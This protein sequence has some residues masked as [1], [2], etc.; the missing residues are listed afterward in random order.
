VFASL[1]VLNLKSNGAL[2]AG[3]NESLYLLRTKLYRPR[4]IGGLVRRP[5][6]RDK[7]ERSIDCPL[8]LV[9][10]PAGYGKTTLLGDWLAHSGHPNAWLTLD[11]DD[12]DPA[13][14]LTYFVAAI[15]T[16]VPEACAETSTLLH[17]PQ[18]PPLT[19][20]ASALHNDLD[21]LHNDPA[22]AGG[23]HFVLV[24]DD[25]HLVH[26]PAVHELLNGLLQRPPRTMHLI[27]STRQ[28]PPLN[29]NALRAHG[30]MEEIRLHDLRFTDEEAATFMQQALGS[31]LDERILVILQERTEGWAAGLRLA[32]L[33][34]DISTDIDSHVRQLP[35]D[36]RYIT[37]Y[38]IDEV[39]SHIPT[40]SQDFLLKTSILELLS[41]PLCDA[42]T[43]M[44]GPVWDGRA[45]LEWLSHQGLFTISL[46]AQGQWYRYHL[47]FRALLRTR[48][49]QR[50][51]SEEIVR[52]H[53]EASTW[54]A[55]HGLVD[56]A[57]R[58]ALAGGDVTATVHL[59]ETHRHEAMNQE[60]WRQLERWL[61]L[62]AGRVI[63][64][65]LEL[66]LLEAWT[67]ENR[68]RLA[69]TA[70]CLEGVEALMGKALLPEG[71]AERLQA[72]IDALRA[73]LS[74]WAADAERCEAFARRALRTAPVEHSGVRGHAWVFLAAAMQMRGDL[75]GALDLVYQGLAEDRSPGSAFAT[76]LLLVLS[77][78]YWISTDLSNMME[79]ANHLLSLA[80]EGDLPE[81][82]TRGQYY[83]GMAHYQRN[84]LAAAESAF[85]AVLERRYVAYPLVFAQSAFG[86]ASVYQA[87]GFADR[88]NAT[89]E[90]VRAY[91]LEMNNPPMLADAQAFGAHLALLQ[92]RN[93]EALYWAAQ[94]DRRIRRAP[95]PSFF[96]PSFALVEILLAKDTPA[97]LEEASQLLGQLRDLVESTHNTRFAI[98][99][100]ALQALLHDRLHDQTAAL[101]ALKQALVLAEPG[102]LIRVFVDLGP[103]MA[104]LLHQLAAPGVAPEYL[105]KLLA[106]FHEVVTPSQGAGQPGLIEPLSARELEVLAL[107][108]ERLSNKEIAREMGISPMTVKRHTVNIYQKLLVQGRREAAARAVELG[109]LS[110]PSPAEPRVHG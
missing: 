33:T 88:A 40:A 49:E 3:K 11:E 100:L 75:R 82:V 43:G 68:F 58:H 13:V 106:A 4:V 37:D 65:H 57:I 8:T 81:S 108:G 89:A 39:L 76:R 36:N 84:N 62:F 91:A 1:I 2:V 78:I 9:C 48:L 55:S 32:A 42:V 70:A 34:L 23:E 59:V 102:G 77:N 86:L 10:A 73:Q 31:P 96:V 85:A 46:D 12:S 16:I 94:C 90:S 20:L 29:L 99:A 44:V 61:G 22:L 95:M 24:L 41:G 7:L 6:V 38:L 25:Y 74:Y 72:E 45:Y 52:L 56:E 93:A 97:D 15:R 19:G 110:S 28:D 18:L 60:R 87:Q 83:L 27:L 103:P 69:D 54:Y 26:N 98:E 53:A 63:D 80:R 92:G 107:L 105:N 5:R 47:L 67:L 17:S 21:R 71:I 30:E 35:A 50:F 66:L 101:A 14:F 104:A 64:S 79:T 51:S 109:I